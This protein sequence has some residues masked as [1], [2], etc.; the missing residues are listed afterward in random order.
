MDY[1]FLHGLEQHGALDRDLGWLPLHLGLYQGNE[2]IAACAGYLTSHSFGDFVYDWQWAKIAATHDVDWYP[3]W[4][5]EVPYSPIAGSRLQAENHSK[6]FRKTLIQA[7]IQLAEQQQLACVQVNY[8]QPQEANQ[9]KKAGFIIRSD[10]QLHWHNNQYQNFND[11]LLAL[12]SKRRKEIR[13]ERRKAAT[14]NI[15]HHWIS[16]NNAG[17]DDIHFVHSCYQKTFCEYGNYPALSEAFLQHICKRLGHQVQFCIASHDGEK[18]ASA[19]FLQSKTHLYGRYW[20]SMADIDCLHFETC[21]YQGIE[22]CIQQGIQVFE[23]GAGGGHKLNRGF[24]PQTIHTAHW[25]Q[26]QRLKLLLSQI[27]L[28]ESRFDDDNQIKIGRHSPFNQN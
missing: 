24:L 3:K 16:G 5:I 22:Y 19:I 17:E 21:F 2:L 27:A 1:Q 26:D 28:Q 13:R 20:G 6:G 7:V 15:T 14:A 23:P 9:L 8:C 12:T 18:L 10:T 25:I 4:V 11:F